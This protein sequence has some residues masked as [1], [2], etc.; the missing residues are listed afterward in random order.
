MSMTDTVAD[1]L[2]R[3]RNAGRAKHRRVDLPA[4][5]LKM[6]I[7]EALKRMNY[8]R[9]VDYV[10]DGKQGLLI[11]KLKYTP[12]SRSVISGLVRI[13]KPGRRIYYDKS[14]LSA[15]SRKVGTVVLS[16]SKGILTDKEA[17]EAGVGGEAL[18]RI[19]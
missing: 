4:S 10:E 13:S 5:N 15:G 11:V 1:L 17:L 8:L 18:F 3:I 14:K 12:D 19:W 16:T 9:S 6:Q 7:A 2:T